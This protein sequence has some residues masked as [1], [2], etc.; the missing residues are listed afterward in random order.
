MA[1]GEQRV[2]HE[3]IVGKAQQELQQEENLGL[4]MRSQNHGGRKRRFEILCDGTASA[5][6]YAEQFD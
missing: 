3:P 6:F 1:I 2:L 4:K 5:Y